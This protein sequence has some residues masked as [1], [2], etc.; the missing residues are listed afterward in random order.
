MDGSGLAGGLW[1]FRSSHS[2]SKAK[3]IKIAAQNIAANAKIFIERLNIPD[4]VTRKFLA[5]GDVRNRGVN[6]SWEKAGVTDD[7]RQK[8]R[9]PEGKIMVKPKVN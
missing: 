6:D 2:P 4:D 5:G 9:T 1:R 7:G 3:E 8:W